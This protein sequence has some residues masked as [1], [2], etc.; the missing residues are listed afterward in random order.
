MRK[1]LFLLPFFVMSSFVYATT[2]VPISI[3][4]Q[5]KESDGLIQ[6][7]VISVTSEKNGNRIVSKVTLLA[8]KWIGLKPDENFI[9]IYYPGG[10][11]GET[12]FDVKGSPK[13]DV[14]ENVVLFTKKH[15]EKNWVNNLGLG[16]FS[17]KI[18]GDKKVLINQIFPG[19]PEVGQMRIDKFY[20]L[21][22][23]VKKQKF[24][25]RY[26]DKYELN[27]DKES[28]ALYKRKIR[29]RS[30]ASIGEKD[31]SQNKLP[32]IWLVVILGGLGIA[33]GVIRKKLT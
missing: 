9:D 7:E 22:E 14:G 28:Q 29:G 19:H 24:E 32:A 20:D 13:F 27:L 16:K 31:E 17:L 10:K 33:V 6:G 4:K 3:K 1:H 25:E 26:K 23:W 18:M 12:V 21:S 30:I 15:K 5:I 11:I 2:F 8:D